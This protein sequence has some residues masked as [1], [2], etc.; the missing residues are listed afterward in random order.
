MLLWQLLGPLR[1]DGFSRQDTLF[2]SVKSFGA[3]GNGRD[4][5]TGAFLKCFQLVSRSK[6]PVVIS[7]PYG[8]YKI[9]QTLNCPLKD[10]P[11]LI[12][13]GMSLSGK[14][15]VIETDKF[16][17]LF[18]IFNYYWSPKGYVSISE[19][20]LRGSNPPYSASHPYFDK[21]AFCSGIHLF[22]LIV[23]RLIDNEIADIYGEGI[24][25]N[26]SNPDSKNLHARFEDVVVARNHVLNCWGLHPTR[27][28]SGSF[29]DYGDGI[30]INSTKKA[31]VFG[32]RVVNQLDK[33]R[34][35]GRA[36]LVLEYNAE[37]CYIHDNYIFGYDRNIH[38]EGDLG[39]QVI[40][41]NTLEGSDF[42]I[43]IYDKPGP[44]NKPDT[45]TG[46]K[47]SNRG[48]PP[49]GQLTRVRNSEERCLLSFYAQRGCRKGSVV[50]GNL[51]QV[52]PEYDYRFSSIVRFL[53]SGL[54]IKGNRFV[55]H[56][57]PGTRKTV[58]IYLA[59][60]SLVG[61]TF[62]NVD[63][64]LGKKESPPEVSGNQVKGRVSSN[65]SL[66]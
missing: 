66:N 59:V 26:Y 41:D 17:T 55:S 10:C 31:E 40:A 1:S 9:S 51:F 5:D 15:P 19:L 18:E 49:D 11:A 35:F 8:D 34:Q 54:V 65:F 27:K 12:I 62:D 57:P 14:K 2:V 16:I 25:I 23:A 61:N 7:V 64:H 37:N 63:V 43:L 3:K 58:N 56:L 20:R 39:G 29:D 13:R 22:N 38:I 45:I 21:S 33:T 4:D 44:V 50:A 36:G 53:A 52:F 24:L 60:D 46:N 30:Y 28:G 47:I 32:N 48:L 42:G 6:R